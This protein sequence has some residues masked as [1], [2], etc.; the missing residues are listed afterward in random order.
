M[1]QPLRQPP[2]AARVAVAA[3]R[4]P[5]GS[6]DIVAAAAACLAALAVHWRRRRLL[7]SAGAALGAGLPLAVAAL[8]L[9]PAGDGP[10]LALAALLL[11]VAIALLL[12]RRRAA[13]PG[14]VAA[15][16]DRRLPALADSA[17]LLLAPAGLPPLQRLQQRRAAVLLVAEPEAR[18]R[19][20]LPRCPLRRALAA[21]AGG[22]TLAVALWLAPLPAAPTGRRLVARP[23]GEHHP[24]PPAQLRGLAVR[25]RPPA[26]T[27]RPARIS[28]GLGA[29]AEE[30]STVSWEVDAAPAVTAAALLFDEA[31]RVPL[32]RSSAGNFTGAA[33]AG[34]PRLVRLLL[35]GDAGELWR[36]PPARLEV[37]ADRPPTLE[38]LAPAALVVQ[39]PAANG[40][41]LPLAVAL[42]DDYGVSAAELV[43]TVAAGSGEEVRFAERRLPLPV[44]Q[45]A[46]RQ[47]VRR[48]LDLSALGFG[49]GNELYLH[50]EARDARRPRPDAPPQPNQVRSPTV[51]VR[52]LGERRQSAPFGTGLPVIV[53][54]ELFRSQRQVVLDTQRLLAEAPRLAAAEVLR[55]SRDIGFDQRALRL[56]YGGLLG[57]EVEEGRATSPE[58]EG[59]PPPGG[60]GAYGLGG[61]AAV[62][63]ALIH[64]HDSAESTENASFFA[65]PVRRKLRAMLAAMWDAEG[66]LAVGTP[67]AAL[68]HELTALDLLKQVQQADRVY[69]PKSGAEGAP[70]DP[71]RRLS[72][73]LRGV[74]DLAASERPLAAEPVLAAALDTLAALAPA[75]GATAVTAHGTAATVSPAALARLRPALAE[76]ARA[77]SGAALD[78]LPA[79]DA[80]EQGRRPAAAA[81]DALERALWELVPFPE[82][83]VRGTAP[84]GRLWERYRAHL[85]GT[86]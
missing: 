50:V 81:R 43:A 3:S 79:L 26:Y 66:A 47:V 74:H 48:T 4:G 37:L 56:R 71:A 85:G 11:P 33:I 6:Y 55:R 7:A 72:G 67:R 69:V 45:Q 53:G 60:A 82:A 32:R 84:P 28:K 40:G 17:V 80:L 29:S 41:T 19:A 59:G 36:S 27:G 73:E 1:S 54:P 35:A 2:P 22:L 21:L 13:D 44:H 12:A 18:L 15:H 16:L 14:P 78:A 9:A 63:G 38:L 52:A 42:A 49:G 39:R 10:P 58:E 86:P 34:A 83:P 30:G 23:S 31:E 20:L 5:A 77:G 70:L 76:R 8:R 46:A 64:E 62:P 61:V 57:Q 24:P 75:T 25:V 68:P 65:E 51:V